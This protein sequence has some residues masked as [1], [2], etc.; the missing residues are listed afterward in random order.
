MDG[1]LKGRRIR[2]NVYFIIDMKA[3][4]RENTRK[5]PCKIPQIIL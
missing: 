4:F 2:Q 3:L 5:I 1:M